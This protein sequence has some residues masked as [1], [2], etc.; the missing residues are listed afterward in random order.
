MNKNLIAGAAIVAVF[1]VIGYGALSYATKPDQPAP[2]STGVSGVQVA[3]ASGTTGATVAPT[4]PFPGTVT[5]SGGFTG[6]V[7]EGGDGDEVTI[8]E[9]ASL[10][11]P[12]CASFHETIY[13]PFK[14]DYIETGKVRF[15]FR[16]YPLDNFAVAASIIARCGGESK[17]LGFID[18]FM[19]Q[20]EKW[21]SAESPIAEL[22]RLAKF[23]GLT[24][25]K[26]DTCMED[27][28]LGQSILDRARVGQDVFEVR[29]T[30]TVLINGKKFAG[31]MNFEG[32]KAEVDGMLD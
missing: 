27:A 15:I 7:P 1:G 16:D 6:D 9:Y 29:S 31:P 14:K 24:E 17:Y 2:A 28:A 30:P 20:Q 21:R 11:C 23:G 5:E 3:D 26:I 18:L 13:V 32:L 12:H 19:S 10:T 4:D 8:I 22:K 25:Q